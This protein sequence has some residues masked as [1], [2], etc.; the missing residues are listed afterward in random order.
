V[1]VHLTGEDDGLVKV[2]PVLA[3]YGDFAAF[4]AAPV[5]DDAQ[6]WW[7]LRQSET[8]GA[9]D[10][11]CGLDCNAGSAQRTPARPAKARTETEA[12]R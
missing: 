4:L 12:V 5:D 11:R 7:V 1:R 9:P 6:A 2:A 10:R 8:S 3:R